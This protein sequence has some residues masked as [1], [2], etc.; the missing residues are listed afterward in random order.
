MPGPIA[1]LTRMNDLQIT[2][3]NGTSDN[4]QALTRRHSHDKADKLI[5]LVQT[6]IR[7]IPGLPTYVAKQLG[8]SETGGTSLE[9]A[10]GGVHDASRNHYDL[11]G[12]HLGDTARTLD[13]PFSWLYRNYSPTFAKNFLVALLGDPLLLTALTHLAVHAKRGAPWVAMQGFSWIRQDTHHG[14]NCDGAHYYHRG[15]GGVDHT[16]QQGLGKRRTID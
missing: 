7:D 1:S 13:Y 11:L 14:S 3:L 8:R 2:Q 16:W 5:A 12:M 10:P 6:I 15:G 4:P 9:V